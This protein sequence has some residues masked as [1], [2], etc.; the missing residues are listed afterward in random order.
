LR[1]LFQTEQA[2]QG[3]CSFWQRGFVSSKK[4]TFFL[5]SK[6]K[7]GVPK[8]CPFRDMKNTQ[9]DFDQKKKRAIKKNLFF[10]CCKPKKKRTES[11]SENKN[12]KKKPPKNDGSANKKKMRIHFSVSA[13][14]KRA[15]GTFCECK[16]E[17]DKKRGF[18][19]LEILFFLNERKT[20]TFLLKKKSKKEKKKTRVSL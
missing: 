12:T 20:Q 16:G 10:F 2:T 19:V 1:F 14:K 17:K 3:G 9:K 13:L 7:N 8:S 18:L 15:L 4:N 6:K 5:K 11:E